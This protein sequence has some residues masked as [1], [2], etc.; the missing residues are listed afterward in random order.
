MEMLKR[1]EMLAWTEQAP[2]SSGECDHCHKEGPLWALP[3]QI[4]KEP[5]A[6]WMYCAACFRAA[7]IKA[8]NA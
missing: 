1:Y 6:N 7:V 4:D 5:Q 2:D 8:T 3:S